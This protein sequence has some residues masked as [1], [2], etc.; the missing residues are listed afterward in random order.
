MID[1]TKVS[2]NPQV[3]KLIKEIEKLEQQVREMDEMALVRYEL[4][5]LQLKE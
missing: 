5:A 4:E 3:I 1:Y 2:S